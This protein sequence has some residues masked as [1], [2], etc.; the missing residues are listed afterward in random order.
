MGF[1]GWMEGWRDGVSW[2]SMVNDEPSRLA[3]GLT[4]G[5]GA[6]CTDCMFA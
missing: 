1:D 3:C 6:V 2:R 5:M 4:G